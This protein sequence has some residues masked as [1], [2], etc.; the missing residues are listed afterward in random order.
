MSFFVRE[1][2]ANPRVPRG[3]IF[4]SV[5]FRKNGTWN[6]KKRRW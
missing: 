2:K 1:L 4:L 3:R 6:G 5:S